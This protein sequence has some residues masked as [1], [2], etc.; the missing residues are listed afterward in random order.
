MEPG[1]QHP[2]DVGKVPHE[3][4]H[5]AARRHIDGDREPN[6]G[7]RYR[8]DELELL[9]APRSEPLAV[10]PRRELDAPRLPDSHE[11][12]ALPPDQGDLLSGG[13]HAAFAGGARQRLDLFQA[14][15]ERSEVPARA[16]RADHPE[17]T[18]PL[19]ER[20][21]PSDAEPGGAAVAVERAVAEGAGAIHERLGAVS[22][23][24]GAVLFDLLPAPRSL[25]P[26]WNLST[27]NAA[28][29]K[30]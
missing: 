4:A 12:V 6:G 10:A 26:Q 11:V 30:S 19:V 3:H 7:D 22:R 23:E 29:S 1:Q 27:R 15:V 24:Q 13:G 21:P 2:R 14:I 5:G 8:H 16:L 28:M 9:A 20:E 17:A 18:L 25:L